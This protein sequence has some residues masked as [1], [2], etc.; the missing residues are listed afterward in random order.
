MIRI[1][2]CAV[3]GAVSEHQDAVEGALA[4]LGE[5]G[6]AVTVRRPDQMEG[7]DG[8]ILPGGES[9]TISKLLDRFELRD[10]LVK[11]V[12]DGMGIMGTCAGMVLLAKEGDE[13]VSRTETR[14]L[15]LVDMEVVRNAFGRQRESFETPIDIE[16]LDDPYNAVFIRAPMAVRTWGGCE[17]LSQLDGETVMV[18]QGRV[19]AL[20]FHPELTQDPRVHSMFIR[21]I[22]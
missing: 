1:G 9:T 4:H 20:S 19:F 5:R 15:G 12:D 3:Q 2:I 10:T 7:L 6:E 17:V 21:S 14:L 22:M 16:G 13:E 11:A 18:R 8:F